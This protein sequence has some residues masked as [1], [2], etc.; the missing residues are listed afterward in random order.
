MPG[1]RRPQPTAPMPPTDLT[2]DHPLVK[3]KVAAGLPPADALEVA[4]RQI[5]HDAALK[6]AAKK[7]LK[8]ESSAAK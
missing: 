1:S 2:A 4:Q 6:A 8:A 3:A 7:S 5:E